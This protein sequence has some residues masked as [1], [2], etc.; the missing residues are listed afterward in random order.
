MH[1]TKEED[2]FMDQYFGTY[3]RFETSSKK[4]AALLLG[5]DNL[6]GDMYDIEFVTESGQRPPQLPVRDRLAVCQ[7]VDGGGVVPMQGGGQH[8]Q[9]S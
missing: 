3:H 6:V 5:A 9:V 7:L 8:I 1:A 2:T 4:D